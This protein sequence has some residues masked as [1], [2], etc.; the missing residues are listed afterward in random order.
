METMADLSQRVGVDLW[1]YQASSGGSIEKALD[2][3][4]PYADSNTPWPYSDDNTP[5]TQGNRDKLIGELLQGQTAYGTFTKWLNL[6][7]SSTLAANETN[8]FV[9]S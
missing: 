9:D 3:L 7:P 1:T 4:A 2:Y 8:L 6:L 5:L